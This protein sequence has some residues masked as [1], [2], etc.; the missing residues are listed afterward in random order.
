MHACES[1]HVSLL[2]ALRVLHLKD[3]LQPL[4]DALDITVVAPVDTVARD[5]WASYEPRSP[6][7]SGLAMSLPRTRR[8]PQ[9]SLKGL[10]CVVIVGQGS[11]MRLCVRLVPCLLSV[12]VLPLSRTYVSRLDRC[13][14]PGQVAFCCKDDVAMDTAIAAAARWTWRVNEDELAQ[15]VAA[16][17]QV[18]RHDHAPHMH[19]RKSQVLHLL[20]FCFSPATDPT[21]LRTRVP[22]VLTGEPLLL[23]GISNGVAVAMELALRHDVVAIWLASGVPAEVIGLELGPHMSRFLC[24]IC[25]ERVSAEAGNMTCEHALW[26]LSCTPR[27]AACGSESVTSA[28]LCS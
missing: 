18:F 4:A 24:C 28:C 16:V 3:D 9:C 27:P 12:L 20:S 17:E 15:A 1:G 22:K 2:R 26:P 23:I 25:Q 14:R 21:C 6:A 8:A 7:T 5:F 13:Q 10:S 19:V 11:H